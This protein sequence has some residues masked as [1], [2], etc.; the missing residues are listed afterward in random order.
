MNHRSPPIVLVGFLLPL[1]L[2]GSCTSA[3][4]ELP[5][6]RAA[7]APDDVLARAEARA[8]NCQRAVA[9]LQ[10]A[11][12]VNAA[13]AE[14]LRMMKAAAQVSAETRNARKQAD[15]SLAATEFQIEKEI[16]RIAADNSRLEE[17]LTSHGFGVPAK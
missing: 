7:S 12:R 13:L 14:Q 17:T 9:R 5:T 15:A 2:L 1:G 10:D 4:H 8:A 11:L 6:S 3:P 16:E